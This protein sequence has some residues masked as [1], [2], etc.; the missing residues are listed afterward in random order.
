MKRISICFGIRPFAKARSYR[1]DEI[2]H[3]PGANMVWDSLQL[4]VDGSITAVSAI[5]PNRR[6]SVYCLWA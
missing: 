6:Q 4:F 5:V 1:F 2:T 3:S